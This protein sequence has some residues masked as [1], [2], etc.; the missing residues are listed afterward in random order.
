M[1]LDSEQDAMVEE[2]WRNYMTTGA[3][4]VERRQ[5]K[6]FQLLPGDPRCK[7]CSAPFKGIGGQFVRIVYGK[8][9][10]KL[11][12]HLCNVCESFADKH[13][14]G[15]EVEMSLLFVDVRGSTALAENINPTD[16]SRL[17]NR[18]YRT[19]THVMAN[20]NGLIDKIIGDQAAAM[21]VPGFVGQ[22][23]ALTAVNAARQILLEVGYGSQE[24]A[25]IPIGAG[26]HTGTA[27]IGSVRSEE[28]ISDI[29]VLG[30]VPNTAARLSSAAG[31]GE[32]MISEA[33]F[34]SSGLSGNSL[35]TR[36]I[37]LKGKSEPVSVRVM[38]LD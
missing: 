26:V 34:T 11:N 31:A 8:G 36:T 22:D 3:T 12:P 18:F 30:D 20:S 9:P 19:A 29:T 14:G 23:H 38:R 6:L 4:D 13:Q 15:A 5:R 32:I 24:G 37:S 16:F 35:E 33:A 21:Y 1:G 2:I 7:F 17:I 28:G 25:W 10:S 27:F